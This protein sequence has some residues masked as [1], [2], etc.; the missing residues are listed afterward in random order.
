MWRMGEFTPEVEVLGVRVM[1][2]HIHWVLKVGRRLPL[3]KPLGI[4]IRGFKGAATKLY[5]AHLGFSAEAQPGAAV[6]SGL[7]S[8][9][10]LFAEGYVD[11]ILFDEQ[12]VA[13]SLA[14][15]NDNPRRLWEKLTH[16]ELFAALRDLP[17]ELGGFVGHFAAIGNHNLLKAHS[18]L[19]VQCSRRLFAYARDAEGRLLKDAPPYVA[20]PEFCESCEVL[21][22]EASHG[23]VLVSP[24][25]SEGEREIARRTF[26]AGHRVITLSNKGFSPLYKPGGKLFDTCAAGNLL[27]LAPANWPYVP[28]EKKMTRID[29][30]VLNRLA[31]H[32]AGPGAVEIVYKGVEPESIDRLAEAA[33]SGSGGRSL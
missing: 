32:I 1:P 18:I 2:D 33:V 3:K 11:N 20:S 14:Y 10:S 22:E 29:A 23:A 6:A 16:P 21:L 31:Q 9:G 24:C 28:G 17:V 8:P 15:L 26:A 30:C 4:A 25:I 19:Q 12:A 7:K 13:N 5:W 27:M